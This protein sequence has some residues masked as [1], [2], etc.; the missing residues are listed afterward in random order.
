MV[1]FSVAISVLALA[2][3][4][5]GSSPALIVGEDGA[6]GTDGRSGGGGDTFIAE[7]DA[8]AST[9]LR[10]H[11]ES[12]PGTTVTFITLACAGACADVLAVASGG[13]EPYSMT[14]EDGS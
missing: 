12:P 11:V 6:G 8:T 10:A 9:E 3:S 1:R 2:C 4:P 5:Q 13:N 14:W 7:R